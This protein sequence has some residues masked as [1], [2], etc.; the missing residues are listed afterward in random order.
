VNIKLAT[1]TLGAALILAGSPAF[2]SAADVQS[3]PIHINNVQIYGGNTPDANADNIITPGSTAIAFT[4]Q[5]NFPATEV[6]FALETQGYVADRFDDVGSFA[7]GVT[8]K[9]T[10]GERELNSEMRVAVEKATFADGTVWVNPAVPQS[11]KADT[12][13]GVA[14]NGSF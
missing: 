9:H 4:N 6:V 7:T 10:F 1:A 14:V 13:I 11:T 12:A 8:I 3:G 2:A 5:Y